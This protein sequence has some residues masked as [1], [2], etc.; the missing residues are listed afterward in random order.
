[1]LHNLLSGVPGPSQL[2]R[3]QDSAVRHTRKLRGQPSSAWR[4][5]QL[6]SLSLASLGWELH[7]SLLQAVSITYFMVTVLLIPSNLL[8]KTVSAKCYFPVVMI[9]WGTIVMAIA[10]VQN[11]GGLL[12]AR[13]FLGIP[14]A[15][16]V[17]ACIMYFS[18][19]YKPTERAWRL[20]VFNAA[21]SLA[22][23]VSSF[24]AVGIDRVSVTQVNMFE[25]K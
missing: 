16:V 20:G 18:F 12:S 21:N 17:P 19:W 8:M 9:L 23:A 13:F 7:S 24:L 25:R 3:N 22:S 4:S 1:M 6:G 14:E 10:S 5:V 2:S 11:A 15:G